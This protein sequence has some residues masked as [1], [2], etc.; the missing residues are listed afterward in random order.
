MFSTDV[1]CFV[2]MNCLPVYLDNQT[3]SSTILVSY[4]FPLPINTVD[5][6]PVCV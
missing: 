1:K 3:V 6:C 4:T 2:I 5:Q